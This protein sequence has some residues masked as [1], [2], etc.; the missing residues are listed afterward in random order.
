MTNPTLTVPRVHLNGT[1]KKMLVE[2][3]TEAY[4]AIQLALSAL[5]QVELHQRD[6]YIQPEGTWEVAVEQHRQR[7]SKLWAVAEELQDIIILIEEQ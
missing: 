4:Q 1:S 5:K 2:T 6:Y 3:Y 7:L